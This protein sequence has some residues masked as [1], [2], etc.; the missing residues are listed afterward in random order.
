M[1]TRSHPAYRASLKDND[2][3]VL[4][5]WVTEKSICQLGYLVL[6]PLPNRA[7]RVIGKNDAY[8]LN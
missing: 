4:T 6:D 3:G 5:L 1:T 7:T 8:L 2:D